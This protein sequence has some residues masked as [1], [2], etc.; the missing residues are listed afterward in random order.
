MATDLSHRH[1]KGSDNL[2]Y[3]GT[4]L[5]PYSINY[6]YYYY[7]ALC[8]KD[9]GCP[10][11]E[12]HWLSP[13]I[14]KKM[15]IHLHIQDTTRL[16]T[17][18]LFFSTSSLFLLSDI[19]TLPTLRPFFLLYFFFLTLTAVVVYHHCFVVLYLIQLY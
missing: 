5:Y 18:K 9:D 2:I 19:G 4:Y 10:G 3:R 7:Y 13:G 14:N 6:Y 15:H 11:V 12:T 1:R 17:L 8:C 16:Y